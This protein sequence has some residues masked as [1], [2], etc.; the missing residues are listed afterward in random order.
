MGLYDIVNCYPNVQILNISRI[1][2]VN[3][4]LS[5]NGKPYLIDLP[6]NM[7][8]LLINSQKNR[9]VY[10]FSP[11]NP[12]NFIKAFIQVDALYDKIDNLFIMLQGE[13]PHD[14][15]SIVEIP[16]NRYGIMVEVECADI[17]KLRDIMSTIR[18]A[19]YVRTTRTAIVRDVIRE[20]LWV[21]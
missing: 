18:N 1:P 3:V 12:G 16:Y 17:A 21:I 4:E 5:V 8:S 19:D 20:N 14:V 6:K 13:H 7:M 2:I 11:F 9:C 10:F 15:R